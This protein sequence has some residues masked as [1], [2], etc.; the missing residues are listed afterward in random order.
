MNKKL[1][2]FIVIFIII[3]GG[4]FC[5]LR[6]SKCYTDI[7]REI[8]GSSM[9][10]MLLNGTKIVSQENYYDCHKIERGDIVAIHI[11]DNNYIKKIVGLPGDNFSFVDGAIYLNNEKLNN[12]IG[13]LYVFSEES[14]E[15][16]NLLLN[17]NS[18][19]EDKYF[20]LGD[21]IESG[22]FDSRQFGFIE[23][24]Q[25]FSKIKY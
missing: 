18:I 9:S 11:K 20:V 3:L 5:I 19:P 16:L 14:K 24:N 4:F 22:V 13:E 21:S 15:M 1:I 8:S 7:S 2:I 23:R 25:I 17:I 10:P 12:S 6:E